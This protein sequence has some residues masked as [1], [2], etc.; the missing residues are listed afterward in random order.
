MSTNPNEFLITII[1]EPNDS[2][3][4]RSSV[5]RRMSYDKSDFINVDFD[6][7]VESMIDTLEKS[8]QSL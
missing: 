6:M 1:V 3:D 4:K 2:S 7:T 8:K 5:I